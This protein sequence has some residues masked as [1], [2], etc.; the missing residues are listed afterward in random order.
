MKKSD[1]QLIAFI[2]A[3]LSAIFLL[4][5]LYAATYNEIKVIGFA[6]QGTEFAYPYAQYAPSLI[7]CGIVSAVIS[8]L[9]WRAS[10]AT[11]TAA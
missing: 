6:G 8:A 5:G 10:K 4:A 3:I 9:M 1:Y 7:M 2:A 11:P